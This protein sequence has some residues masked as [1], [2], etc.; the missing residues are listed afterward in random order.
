VD[1]LAVIV[2]FLSLAAF[3]CYQFVLLMMMEDGLFPGSR[4]KLIWGGCFM[5][6]WPAAPFAFLFWRKAMLAVAKDA[7]A[8]D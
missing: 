3:W 5:L 4:D 8:T 2:I 6:L 7:K 1:V